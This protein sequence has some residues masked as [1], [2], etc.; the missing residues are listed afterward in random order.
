MLEIIDNLKEKENEIKE[1][2]NKLP[3]ELSKEEKLINANFISFNEDMF[4]SAILK[5]SIFF[6]VVENFFMIKNQNIRTK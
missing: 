2:K 4:Y 3:F 1:L 6:G 5:I